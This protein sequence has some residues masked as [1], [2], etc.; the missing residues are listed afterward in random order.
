MRLLWPGGNLNW[1]E[2]TD[3]ETKLLR[4]MNELIQKLAALLKKRL[5]PKFQRKSKGQGKKPNVEYTSFSALFLTAYNN[6][7]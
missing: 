6:L 1:P 7:R 5:C 2:E 4:R 3:D